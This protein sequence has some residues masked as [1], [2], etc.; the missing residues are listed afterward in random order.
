IDLSARI[1]LGRL[2]H[3]R[4]MEAPS[5]H[6]FD[7]ITPAKLAA[8]INVG[9]A[10]GASRYM[11]CDAAVD[12]AFSFLQFPKLSSQAALRAALAKAVSGGAF[13]YAALGTERDGG[14][15]VRSDLVSVGRPVGPDE[16]VLS[17]GSFVLSPAYA[18]SLRATDPVAPAPSGQAAGQGGEPGK[19]A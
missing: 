6:I 4:V 2:V 9:D 13:G 12:A 16:I 8:L 5:N 3:D 10:E 19:G 18:D 7:S 11:H 17:S 14:I 1:G 15:E